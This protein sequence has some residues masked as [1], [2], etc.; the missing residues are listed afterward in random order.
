MTL[1]K[2]NEKEHNLPSNATVVSSI[3]VHPLRQFSLAYKNLE[4][5]ICLP[6]NLYFLAEEV[7][8]GVLSSNVLETVET[9]MELFSEFMAMTLVKTPKHSIHVE[10][11]VHHPFLIL[12]EELWKE[13][14]TRYVQDNHVHVGAQTHAKNVTRVLQVYYQV[15]QICSKQEINVPALFNTSSSKPHV[16]AVFGGQG[17]T[18]D[19][20]SELQLAWKIYS[21]ILE[22]FLSITDQHLGHLLLSHVQVKDLFTHGLSIFVWLQKTVPTPPQNYLLSAPVSLPLIA[23]T[24]LAWYYAT[25]ITTN[26]TFEEARSSLHATTGHSQGILSAVVVSSSNTKSEFIQ[27]TLKALTLAFHIGTQATR[28]FP[29]TSISP[30]A[31][32]DAQAHGEREPLPMLLITL[33]LETVRYHVEETNRHLP[34]KKKIYVSL[35]NGPKSIVVSGPPTSLHGLNLRLRKLKSPPNENMARIP[36]Q[37]RQM[38][39]SAQFLPITAPFHSPYLQPAVNEIEKWIQ[40]EKLT[41]NKSELKLPV[42]CTN[43]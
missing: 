21:P 10:D 26:L 4:L 3:P 43:T 9:E 5:N 31:L 16:F 42:F 32:Q 17:N 1:L 15:Q 25:V 14:L 36:S 18:L 39:F 38:S 28:A 41:W 12:L 40:N 13:F 20:F 22:D 34:S 2:P 8:S 11:N 23:L 35:I 37:Q 19:Y 24:Q 27:N 30:T 6:Q 33:P 7:K 29:P